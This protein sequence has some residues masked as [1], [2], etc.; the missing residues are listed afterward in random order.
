M[1]TSTLLISALLAFSGSAQAASIPDGP[2]LG[3]TLIVATTGEVEATFL[4][5]YAGYW[6]SLF[7]ES[8]LGASGFLFDKGTPVDTT[9][10][11]GSFSAGTELTFRLHVWN[12]GEDFFTGVGSLNRDGLPHALAVT[13]FDANLDALVTDVG[14]EDLYGGGDKDYND[15]VFRLTNVYDPPPPAGVPEPATLALL[16]LGMAGIGYRWRRRSTKA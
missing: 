4:G 9:I 7:L 13:R 10:D 1:R 14:F 11:L 16:G 5:S 3:G 12:T 15:F 6:N 8:A 2:V